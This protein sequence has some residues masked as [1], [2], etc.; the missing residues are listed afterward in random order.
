MTKL[1]HD[2]IQDFLNAL[3]HGLPN[4]HRLE[5]RHHPVR[6]DVGLQLLRVCFNH[7]RL[8]NLDCN[9]QI[10]NK[11]S[12]NHDL[13]QFDALLKEMR[14]DKQARKASGKLAVGS[15]IKELALPIP[16]HGYPPNFICAL[17]RSHL[18]NLERFEIPDI[19]R[20]GDASCRDSLREAVAQG[21]PKLQHL[22]CWWFE[23]ENTLSGIM[24]GCREWG[25]KSLYCEHLND[26]VGYEG[27]HRFMKTLVM[28]HFRT[29]EE[30]E[31]VNCQSVHRDDFV[32]LFSMCRNLKKV[33]IQP[34]MWSESTME[35]RDVASRE[36]VCHDL[37]ELHPILSGSRN[38]GGTE[39]ESDGDDV[40][41]DGGDGGESGEDRGS[42]SRH[43]QSEDWMR[44]GREAYR[45]IGRLLKLEALCLDCDEYDDPECQYNLTLERGWL[46]ELAGLKELKHLHMR[47]DFWSRMGQAE[48]EFMHAQWPKLEMI[49]FQTYLEKVLT[50][51]HWQWLQERRPYLRFESTG[52]SPAPHPFLF[53]V[54]ELVEPIAQYLSHEDIVHCMVTCKAWS[55]LFEPFLWQDVALEWLDPAPQ[56]LAR[57]RHCIRSLR[58]AFN[59]YTNL[60]TLAD[61][62]PD[63][64]SRG[65]DNSSPATPDSSRESSLFPRLRTICFHVDHEAYHDTYGYRN[66]CCDFIVRIL[67]QSPG[68]TKIT[69]PG[70]FLV[71]IETYHDVP[72]DYIQDFLNTL[73]YRLPSLHQL[74]FRH[75]IVETDVGLQLLR[76]CF[77]HPQLANLNCNIQIGNADFLAHN[78]QFNAFLKE[79]GDDK[80]AREASGKLAA[81]SRI[82]ELVLPKTYHGYPLNFICT[83]LKSHLPNL[84]QF[85]IP[86]M[87]DPTGDAYN[88]DSLRE[89]V[90]QGCPK[91][92]HIRCRWHAM[93]ETVLG[94]MEGCREWGLRSFFCEDLDDLNGYEYDEYGE[95]H[96]YMEI[97]V[98]E[99]F[100]TLE[101][102]E[103]VSCRSVHRD[104]LVS[105]FST[106]RNLKMVKI[107]PGSR[108]N[109]AMEFR[110]V[111]SREWV[112]HD[113][114]ELH[115]ILA[116]SRSDY[117]VSGYDWNETES[118][119]DSGDGLDDDGLGVSG[120]DG[121][122]CS[123][124]SESH[125]QRSEYRMRQGREAY[126]QIGRLVKLETLYL[127]CHE[128]D[129]PYGLDLDY[130]YD[131]TLER[132][133]LRELAGLKELKHLHM[134]ADFWS[135]MGQAEVEFMHAQWPRL[136]MITFRDRL[137]RVIF[138]PHWEWLQRRRPRL[139][140]E[141]S[142]RSIHVL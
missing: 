138:K 12:L 70:E 64:S 52:A 57:N 45:Q 53:D 100:R 36:W 104:D 42:D 111:V 2:H 18:P 129:D 90:A 40:H 5:F 51:P 97:L 81:G 95:G 127:D 30:V 59:D 58:V 46:G 62:L 75:H 125:R 77:N 32:S 85:E 8:V 10:G 139:E 115:L 37:K 60:L 25:L 96:R 119:S 134:G 47:A 15:R 89:A 107:A 108:I 19:Q 73:A 29:L 28:D 133:W 1:T 13:P 91:L 117:V 142:W 141:S 88:R 3:A 128:H 87:E 93:D 39:F 86:N 80:Q 122:D 112:C 55:H 7:P 49:T 103:L 114:K 48:V 65:L 99:H 118:E 63:I 21:C 50:S 132:G 38:P 33:E 79:L 102:V 31:L 78:M 72:H 22:R 4:L 41:D 92:Q 76:E 14:D 43:Q 105:L 11:D 74:E 17:L 101:R 20:G 9:I 23:Q 24:E 130:E 26:L 109:T 120:G 84:E 82:K 106:C 113:L 61:D 71:P 94:I 69:F 67:C 6:T 83:L 124:D 66:I 131:L 116:G 121:D 54:P 68:V 136:E 137:E 34:S 135:R 56:T 16:F 27:D 126:R 110:D 35:F 98:M 44:Q 123:E 140:L